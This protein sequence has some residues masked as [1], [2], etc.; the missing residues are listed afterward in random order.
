M[1]TVFTV[2]QNFLLLAVT[3]VFVLKAKPFMQ[4]LSVTGTRFWTVS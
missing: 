1:V 2:Q 4:L 3:N